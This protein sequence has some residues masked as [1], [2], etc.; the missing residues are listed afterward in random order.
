MG[1]APKRGARPAVGGPTGRAGRIDAGVEGG[2]HA[3]IRDLGVSVQLTS[4]GLAGGAKGS[5]RFK[6]LLIFFEAK[7]QSKINVL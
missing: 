6:K 4:V 5:C 7:Y 1:G 3:S 2:A